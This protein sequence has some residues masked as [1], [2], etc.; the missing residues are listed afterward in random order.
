M[1]R[2]PVII[3][4]AS[5]VIFLAKLDVLPLF[6][7]LEWGQ[8][9]LPEAV[10]DEL[11]APGAPA[12]LSPLLVE[13]LVDCQVVTVDHP[14]EYASALSHADRCVLALA[15]TRKAALVITDDLPLR[16]LA[17]LHGVKPLGTLGVLLLA[18]KRGLLSPD[19][20]RNHLHVLVT[21]H[22]F[23]IGV[24]VYAEFQFQIGRG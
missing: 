17:T 16:R 11:L 4:D 5:P 6:Q 19:A 10:R 2:K 20:A 8:L 18:M 12:V 23:R 21:R 14:P 24:D 7:V 9:V 3:L 22:T 1:S 15:C 13:F